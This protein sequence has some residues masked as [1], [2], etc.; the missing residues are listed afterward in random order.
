M[1]KQKRTKRTTTKKVQD[2]ENLPAPTIPQVEVKPEVDEDGWGIDGLTIRQRLFVEAIVGPAA[3]NATKAAEMAGYK[4]DNRNALA[5]GAFDTLRIPNVQRAI[6]HAMAKRLDSPEWVRNSLI[7]VAASSMANFVRVNENGSTELD[8]KTAA[9][10]GA[11]SQVRKYRE[12]S[13]KVGDGPAEIIDRSIEVHDRRAAL[14]TL[15][16]LDGKMPA[17]QHHHTHALDLSA[18]SDDDL[19]RLREI[20]AR[21]GQSPDQLARN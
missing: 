4:S 2:T 7:D 12:K 13:I 5:V 6:S 3:G 19:H 20:Y 11:M 8:F 10:V 16:K 17:E 21:A 9:S 14:E 18:L 15:A 1:A